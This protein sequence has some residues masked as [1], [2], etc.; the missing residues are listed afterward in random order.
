MP[1]LPRLW[2]A[3]H[4]H[5]RN[6]RACGLPP[7]AHFSSGTPLLRRSRLSLN[8]LLKGLPTL[9]GAGCKTAYTPNAEGPPVQG[10]RLSFSAAGRQLSLIPPG[11]FWNGAISRSQ[12]G[13]VMFQALLLLLQTGISSLSPY[14]RLQA[15]AALFLPVI[16]HAGTQASGFRLR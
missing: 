9:A 14:R 8:W 16:N 4:S 1:E 3:G 15:R 13:Q 11:D 2:G 6:S 12:L 10:T 7:R 5:P